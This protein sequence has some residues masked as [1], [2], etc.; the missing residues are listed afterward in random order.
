[1]P[2]TKKTGEVILDGEKI[3]IKEGGLR[4]QLKV[5]KNHKFTKSELNKIKKIEIGEKFNFLGKEFK[6]TPL[7]SKRVNLAITLMKK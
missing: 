2:N 5:P 1:M 4:S 3:K 6:K 7:M